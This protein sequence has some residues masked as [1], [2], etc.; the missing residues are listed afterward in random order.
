MFK[1]LKGFIEPGS[2][3]E[4]L[5]RE[6]DRKNLPA[7]V[8][9]IMDGNGRWA[10]ARGLPRI[11]G[12]RAAIKTVREIVETAAR[13]G[14]EV[15]S[16]F[17]F[18]SENWKRP[19]R[20]V[21]A[22]FRVL[23]QYLKKEDHILV[24]NDLRLKV[25]GRREGLPASLLREIDRVEK[26]SE[27]HRHMVIGLALN[28]GSRD[29]IVDAIRSILREGRLLPDEVDEKAVAGH[30]YTA[31]LPDPDLLIRT[32]GELRVSNFLLWQIAYA[33]IWTTPILWPDFRKEDFFQALLDFQKRDRRFGDI[34]SSQ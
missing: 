17:A 19:R 10:Q 31:G 2:R 20:E 32:S 1:D 9:I 22:L 8:A 21:S 24:E 11:E 4:S 13:T 34:R 18:S 5:V 25:L 3:A 15:L 6:L 12:H 14:I 28:Y 16:L 29:E 7:H 30:L 23:E 26:M 33:E 27:L